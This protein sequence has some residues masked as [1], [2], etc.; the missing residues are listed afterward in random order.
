MGD[1]AFNVIPASARIRG[2]VRS[3]RTDTLVSLRN[4]VHRIMN[5][6]CALHNCNCTIRFAPDYYPPTTNNEELFE[7]SKGIA[8]L[9]SREGFLRTIEPTM[10]GEDFAFFST[11]NTVTFSFDWTE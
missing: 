10:G 2:T 1:G 9:V 8:S 5:Q 11:E 6:T 4:K 3:L 7:W